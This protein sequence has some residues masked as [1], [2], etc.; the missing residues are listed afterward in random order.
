MLV[1]PN[2]SCGGGPEITVMRGER[3]FEVVMD[4]DDKFVVF[5][6]DVVFANCVECG[7][8]LEF[9]EVKGNATGK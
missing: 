3:R 4:W 1:A 2:C 5:K 9:K 6:G 7:M 8:P